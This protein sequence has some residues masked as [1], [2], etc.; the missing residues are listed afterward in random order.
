MK[1]SQLKIANKVFTSRLMIGTGKFSS[2]ASMS[3][4]IE[5]SASEIVTVALRRVNIQDPQDNI[6]DALNLDKIQLLPNTAGAKN[7]E[8]AIRLARLSKAS[9]ITN[10]VK[11]E[12][13]PEPKYLLPDG[14]ETLRAAEILVKEG[15][16]VLPYIQADPILA[17]K[18]EEVGTSTVMPLAAPIGSNKG[19]M[20]RE[21]IQI[22]I[23]ESSVPVVVDAGLGSP[24]DAAM[25]MELGAD[26]VL[27][28]TAIA[29]SSKPDIFADAF[30]LATIA[31]RKAY[32]VGLV[33][34]SQI[35]SASS[36]L[37]GISS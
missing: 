13:T 6:L 9:G 12:V 8:E 23:A 32:E 14:E 28:N 2:P 18:L 29:I 20:T 21:M 36:P 7:A 27:V 37:V 15:F 35:A 10:W 5:S 19:L 17:K 1:N 11:L 33:Q 34:K 31:G 25:A 4:A 30:R 24:S 3:V 26:A 22:I 16:V